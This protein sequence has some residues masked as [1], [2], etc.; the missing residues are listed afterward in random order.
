MFELVE[1]YT[2]SA[3]IK[4][5]GVGGGGGNAVAQMID[6][7]IEGVE[8]I[9]ANTDAQALNSA[10]VRTA[11]QIGC[12]IT[13]GLGA[14]ADPD[15]GR[16]AAME[17][18]DRIYEVI[19]GADMLFITAGMGGG[20]GTGAAISGNVMSEGADGARGLVVAHGV[21]AEGLVDAEAR[22]EDLGANVVLF[23]DH[24]ADDFV[25]AMDTEFG[26]NPYRGSPTRAEVPSFC[27]RCHSDG[28]FMRQ[29]NP[30]L[31]VDQVAEYWTSRHG[32]RLAATGDTAVATCSDCHAPHG[33]RPAS[34]PSS[35]VYP[36]TV[37]STC[38]RC[39]DD[40]ARMG[41]FD[42]P[43]DQHEKF[44]RSVHREAMVDGGDISAPT[45]NDCHGNHGAAP[46]GLSW[47]GNV[48]GQC[49]A[50]MADHFDESQHAQTLLDLDRQTRGRR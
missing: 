9:A 41:A 5:I 48:C 3:T 27:G 28:E 18:R 30:S 43:V 26:P 15:I 50:V 35:S 6:A 12:N 8:F 10:R 40:A 1:N 37:A 44:E 42:I 2:P 4:V 36:P 13:K 7:S 29:F 46:P 14:G 11:L 45:C 32:Q 22:E 38:G 16:Q 24:H 31:R 47:V 33:I 39:H 34:D 19:E 20:T 25:A 17:D 21:M 23:V 49:H